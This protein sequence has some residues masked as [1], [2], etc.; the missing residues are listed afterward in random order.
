M[1][2]YIITLLCIITS[3]FVV[4]QDLG[5]PEC[6]SLLLVSSWRGDNVKIYDGCDGHYIRDL[7]NSGVLDGPQAIFEASNGNVVVVSESNHKLIQFDRE[8][9]SESTVLITPGIIPNPISAVKAGSPQVYLG[10]YS[11]NEIIELNS[12]NWNVVRTILPANNGLVR[13]I[14]I[15]IGLGPSGNLYVPGYD[16]D[17]ILKV[18][19]ADGSTSQFVTSGA[20]GLDRPR[21]VLFNQNRFL[22]TAW[23]NRAI[24]SYSLNGQFQGSVVT[25]LT[26]AAGMIQDGPDHILV[27]SD[28]LNTVRRYQLSDFSFQ[29]L[30]PPNSGG[31][32]GATY[33]YR[34]EKISTGNDIPRINHTWLVGV[35]DIIDRTI[36][37]D[38]L[39]STSG[40][41]F[42][43]NFDPEEIE[44][45][46]WGELSIEFNGCHSAAMS[47]HSDSSFEGNP[48]GSGGYEIYRIAMNAATGECVTSG[49]ENIENNHYMS[50]TF[51][52]G[53]A[54]NGEGFFV[55][56]LENNRAVVA[57]F[58][59]LPSSRN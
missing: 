59:Y 5:N 53:D 25:G 50:G 38:Y 16:S 12:N 20:N 24:H 39:S 47:Y 8:T 32:S 23:G 52:G 17:S 51:S 34:L 15:G 42:G 31:L 58:T 43:E 14:D 49:F 35:G 54:R 26:G 4:A 18:N 41:A 1:K 21:T 27:T 22:V 40:G 57:W 9:L 37:I 55:D 7:A 33:V 10:S 29:T 6:G 2:N 44:G 48:F 19:P 13:G 56:L 45:V 36:N 30:V 11:S 3:P 46:D 28:T